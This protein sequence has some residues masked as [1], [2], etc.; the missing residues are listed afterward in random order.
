MSMCLDRLQGGIDK[1]TFTANIKMFA[2][3]FEEYLNEEKSVDI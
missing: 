3:S 2:E 1:E